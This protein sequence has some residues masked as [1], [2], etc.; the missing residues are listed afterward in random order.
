MEGADRSRFMDREMLDPSRVMETSANRHAHGSAMG[1]RIG[2]HAG[3]NL[4][5]LKEAVDLGTSIMAV[6]YDGGVIVGADSRT[7][8]GVYISNRVSDKLTAVDE[9]IFVCRSGSAADTQAISDYVTYFLDQHRQM[10]NGPP[11]VATA[12]SLFRELVYNNKNALMA[13]IICAGWDKY[14]GG[15][16][17]AV[18]PGGSIHQRDFAIGGSGSTYI[19]GFCDA[20]YQP[21]MTSAQCEEF[22]KKAL[23]HAMARDGSS[24]GVIRTVKIDASGNE[25]KFYPGNA[26]PYG[27]L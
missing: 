24:G 12:A 6:T 5:F 25:R 21:G 1:T 20:Y 22:V 3:G 27:P 15:Q 7:S 8:T 19:Y 9:R 2:E 17:F 14:K 18:Q 23:S 16:V 26:L 13:Q 11:K 4:D 10:I